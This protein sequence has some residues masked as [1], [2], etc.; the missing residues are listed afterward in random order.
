MGDKY[1]NFAEL[2][3]AETP[4]AWRVRL[5][6][7]GSPVAVVA[8]HGGGIEPGTSEI[9]LAIAGDDLSY[10]LFEGCRSRGNRDLHLASAQFDEP[11]CLALLA[12][13]SRVVTVHGERSRRSCVFLGG[14]D[15]FARHA[16]GAALREAGF[17]V[18]AGTAPRLEGTGVANLTNL[19]AG[20]T[21]LQLELSLGLRQE[22][23]AA[24]TR[25]GRRR[26]T[27]RLAAFGMAV[28]T[29]IGG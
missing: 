16:V 13:V 6:E 9:A 4:D 26:P 23:F 2:A 12:T 11:R 24:L 27:P 7:S 19:G 14:R 18:A 22:F 10:Y 5:R 21:G 8:P 3:L 20:R 29:A 25:D 1:R 15:E 28:R 17:D